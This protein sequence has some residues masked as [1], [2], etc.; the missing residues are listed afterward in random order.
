[1]TCAPNVIPNHYWETRE[2]EKTTKLNNTYEKR[3]C[4]CCCRLCGCSL[5]ST[6]QLSYLQII[7]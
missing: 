2:K 4:C 3:F 5:L 6:V 7:C 1:M